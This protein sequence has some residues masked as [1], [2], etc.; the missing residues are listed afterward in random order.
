VNQ[1]IFEI[2][3]FLPHRKELVLVPQSISEM[4]T[5]MFRK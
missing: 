3:L 4:I 2:D 1:S 5:T